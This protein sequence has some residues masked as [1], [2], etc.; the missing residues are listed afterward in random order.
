MAIFTVVAEYEHP[1]AFLTKHPLHYIKSGNVANIPWIT[2][3]NT[4]EGGYQ[5][6]ILL[7]NST[8]I[9]K[10][11]QNLF[12]FMPASLHYEEHFSNFNEI[13]K[14]LKDYYFDKGLDND[15]KQNLTDVNI[16]C[17]I[18]LAIKL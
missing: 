6:S 2:G 17:N 15:I 5:S 8:H 16:M 18:Y 13:T 1:G 10:F 14:K 9:E 12:S 3:I 11:K 4:N 7:S